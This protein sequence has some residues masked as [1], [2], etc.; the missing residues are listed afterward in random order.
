[1]AIENKFPSVRTSSKRIGMAL[2]KCGFNQEVKYADGITKRVYNLRVK[3][4]DIQPI[5]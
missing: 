5:F 1:L 4:D 3:T 2:K